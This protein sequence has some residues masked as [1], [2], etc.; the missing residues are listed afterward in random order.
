MIY[1]CFT[2]F[3]ELDLLKIRLNIL[4]DV[5]DKFVLVES[6]KTF[7]NKK[8]ELYYQNNKHLFEKFNHK[9]I[10]II[11]DDCPDTDNPWVIEAYQRNAISRALV[12]CL[13]SDTII[14][15]DVDEIP[16]PKKIIL[17][18]DRAG[19]KIF[20]Q[21]GFAYYFN[22][23]ISDNWYYPKML[24]YKDFKSIL[25][26]NGSYT[27]S[28]A[29][30]HLSQGCTADKI[31]WHYTSHT[32]FIGDGGWHFSSVMSNDK[33]LDK[34]K[35]FSH[36]SE[37]PDDIN[38]SHISNIVNDSIKYPVIVSTENLP[39]YIVDN[40]DLLK[41]YILPN[42][43]FNL[44]DISPKKSDTFITIARKIAWWIPFGKLRE[45]IRNMF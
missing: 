35:S 15:T 5:V 36:S 21:A 20:K 28:D 1:D 37:Y 45:K 32:Y 14:I 39:Q 27:T 13:D 10:H 23:F 43:T 26:G 6:T 29:R 18:K 8:K 3:N 25:H 22:N 17:H 2:F 24:S 31:R 16:N 42:A 7:T 11:V 30:I 41:D 12:D 19:I 44:K 33:V 9:I 40:Q 34:I 38:T 4:N